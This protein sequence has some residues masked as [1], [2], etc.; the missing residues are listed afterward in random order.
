MDKPLVWVS[1]GK[2]QETNCQHQLW[3]KYSIRG[4]EEIKKVNDWILLVT[5]SKFENVYKIKN[6]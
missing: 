2:R 6:P 5:F 1:R 3:E 4:V